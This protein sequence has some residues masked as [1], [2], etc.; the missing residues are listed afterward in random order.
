VK[1]HFEFHNVRFKIQLHF[2]T[3]IFY[4]QGRFQKITY[5]IPMQ[6]E[7]RYTWAIFS[8]CCIDKQLR[9][10][11]PLIILCV[12]LTPVTTNC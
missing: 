11:C 7:S 4:T 5:S 2:F 1:N 9:M 10:N 8:N 6:W 12:I 3:I